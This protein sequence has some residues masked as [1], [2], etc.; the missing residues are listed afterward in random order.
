MPRYRYGIAHRRPQNGADDRDRERRRPPIYT[1]LTRFAAARYTAGVCNDCG[2][3]DLYILVLALSRA[4]QRPRSSGRRP[5]QRFFTIAG[6]F[7]L[8][9]KYL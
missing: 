4:R 6:P 3:I 5:V 2:D 7:D 1:A 8:E 9:F